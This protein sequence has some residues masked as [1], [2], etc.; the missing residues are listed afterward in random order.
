[1]KIKKELNNPFFSN[2]L[3]DNIKSPKFDYIKVNSNIGSYIESQIEQIY[4][5]Y[6]REKERLT[7]E[8]M[9]IEM[10]ILRIKKEIFEM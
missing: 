2:K 6:E 5:F 4:L 3:D 8:L 1:M 9:N 7:Q 10:E